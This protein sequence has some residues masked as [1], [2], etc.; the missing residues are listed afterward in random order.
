[1]K[2][3]TIQANYEYVSKLK[4]PPHKPP[5]R[6]GILFRTLVRIL[7]IPELFA[8]RFKYTS[9][10]MHEAG[11]GPYLILM[12]HSSFI[13]LKIASKILYPMPYCI[14][15]TSDGFVGKEWLMRNIGCIPTQKFVTDVTLIKDMLYTIKNKKTS[16][17]MYP[18]ASYSFDGC[19]TP[20]PSR[21]GALVKKLNVPVL[22]IMTEGAFL[23]DPLYNGLQKRKTRVSAHLTCLLTKDEIKNKSVDDLSDILNKAFT[24]DN[25]ARQ[26]ESRTA[27]KESFRADGL[28]RIL[29]K[30][31]SCK[32]EGGM[33]GKG[34]EIKCSN[35]GKS[36][37]LDIYG[38]LNCPTGNTEF[39]H[40]PDWYSW[41]R[42]C[43]VDEIKQQRYILDTE[44]EIGIVKDYK[45]VYLVGNGRLTHTCDGFTLT[46]CNG[47]LNY[48][49]PALS[50]YGLYADYFWY[51]IGD[52]I[53][54]GDRECL[55]YCFPKSK[56]NVAKARI[57]AEEI[58][59]LNKNATA[60]TK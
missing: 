27:I 33:I 43:V 39:P 12:N 17:L 56:A 53:C 23:Y 1:M 35:C 41:Q 60:Y 26:Y 22:T 40:I 44:V 9:N 32:S 31:A 47:K 50:S 4:C 57:A 48:T 10:R 29:Y 2:I 52:V 7:S 30:C 6:P 49:Q 3:K 37:E 36:Y 45:A 24:F 42:S 54:I 21:L 18:E 15:C 16:V 25:F 28:E 58:Y 51:E 8:V 11:P 46:G 38:R 5:K 55:Y 59:K 34:T 13:D 19:A 20:I 14:V